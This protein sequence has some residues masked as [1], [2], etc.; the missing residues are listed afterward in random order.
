MSQ[1]LNRRNFIYGSLGLGLATCTAKPTWAAASSE[2]QIAMDAHIPLQNLK[3][4]LGDKYSISEKINLNNKPKGDLPVK[5]KSKL[6][7]L[8]PLL[9]IFLYLFTASFLLNFK[10]LACGFYLKSRVNK[11]IFSKKARF[12]FQVP[13]KGVIY[14]PSF[15]QS[16]FAISLSLEKQVLKRFLRKQYQR[17][18]N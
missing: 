6:Q 3:I 15:R 2:A 1:R 10:V 5:E 17:Q 8:Q 18:S 14:T 12:Y 16:Y 13:C 11:M 4:A 9:L 7:Q